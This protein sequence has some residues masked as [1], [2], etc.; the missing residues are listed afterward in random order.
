MLNED[1]VSKLASVYFSNCGSSNHPQKLRKSCVARGVERKVYNPPPTFIL[2]TASYHGS[3]SANGYSL[4]FVVS[5]KNKKQDPTLLQ[6][7]ARQAPS[8]N[9]G[10]CG[11][12]KTDCP[13]EKPATCE[14]PIV[15][16]NVCN[17]LDESNPM[18]R[19]CELLLTTVQGSIWIS[20]LARYSYDWL[21]LVRFKRPMVYVSSAFA[22]TLL[23]S[24]SH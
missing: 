1:N 18:P 16:L 21:R 23:V 12:T 10:K 9:C 5:S 4:F 14:P 11:L 13:N 17:L 24:T 7:A 8:W 19:Y 22:A 20:Y 2:E 6:E 3:W 15:E